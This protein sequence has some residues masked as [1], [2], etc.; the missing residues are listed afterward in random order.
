MASPRT[1]VGLT[2][3]QPRANGA[4]A[5]PPMAQSMLELAVSC[6]DDTAA[7]HSSLAMQWLEGAGRLLESAGRW[8]EGVREGAG[9]LM[10]GA[11]KWH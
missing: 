9:R 8:L 7:L 5:D 6:A 11:G 10:Q 3:G 4:E 1:I 2:Q